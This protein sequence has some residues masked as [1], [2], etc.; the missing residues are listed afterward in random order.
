MLDNFNPFIFQYSAYFAEY[1]SMNQSIHQ[2]I[3]Q[4]IFA[5][6]LRIVINTSIHLRPDLPLLLWLKLFLF[7]VQVCH[8]LLVRASGPTLNAPALEARK[9]TKNKLY[10]RVTQPTFSASFQNFQ[11]MTSVKEI[12][13]GKVL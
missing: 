13:V 1:Q 8:M 11:Q 2:S 10:Q 4:F 9:N 3:N 5:S 7:Y 6:M 12:E